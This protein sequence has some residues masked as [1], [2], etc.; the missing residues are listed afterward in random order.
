VTIT[1]RQIEIAYN[2]A[3]RVFVR[4]LSQ[5]EGVADL[6][7]NEGLNINSAKDLINNYRK[8]RNG[9]PFHR[10]M[11]AHA[12]DYYLERIESEHGARALKAGIDSV[13]GY[14]EYYE[15]FNKG[16]L[17]SMREVVTKHTRRLRSPALLSDHEEEFSNLVKQALAEPS[18]LRRERLRD[19]ARIPR[20]TTVIAEV[21][22]RNPD[23][24][25]EVLFLARGVCQRCLK[26]APFVRRRDSTPYLEV[27]HRT[28]LAQGGEDTVENS[29]ALCPNCHREL[30]YGQNG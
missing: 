7:R 20:K 11:S 16:E 27:H 15:A 3:S 18:S 19:A 17:Q 6:H 5:K 22:R 13:L 23:V 8:M 25:A 21:Y 12:A 30:H 28:V 4:E 10:S 2:I 24:V 29:I 26:H 14:I 1:R 9:E